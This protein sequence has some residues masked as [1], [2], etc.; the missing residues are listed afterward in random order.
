ML[1][2]GNALLSLKTLPAKLKYDYNRRVIARELSKPSVPMAPAMRQLPADVLEAT[3][4]GLEFNVEML[5]VLVLELQWCKDEIEIVLMVSFADDKKQLNEESEELVSTSTQ[6]AIFK[7][8]VQAID[9]SI[10]VISSLQSSA[11][12]SPLD[13]QEDQMRGIV[14]CLPSLRQLLEAR[15]MPN[16]HR[17]R[18][19]ISVLEIIQNTTFASSVPQISSISS[20]AFTEQDAD[21]SGSTSIKTYDSSAVNTMSAATEL[22]AKKKTMT[23]QQFLKEQEERKASEFASNDFEFSEDLSQDAMQASEVD[24]DNFVTNVDEEIIYDTTFVSSSIPSSFTEVESNESSEVPIVVDT[25]AIEEVSR[26]DRT[27]QM[28]VTGIDVTF[29]LLESLFKAVGPILAGGGALFVRRV[30]QTLDYSTV[31]VPFSQWAAARARQLEINDGKGDKR[32]I[33]RTSEE[34]ELLQGFYRT[35]GARRA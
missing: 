6:T 20:A 15:S 23:F 22:P 13:I 34:W 30:M 25:T 9:A 4:S 31:R 7:D 16:Q 35:A 1:G 10:Q 11:S 27:I 18:R 19:L 2:S 32:M 3:V 29:F 12:S 28:L 5:K 24:V 21:L 17:W 14:T 26:G 8:A 33:Y